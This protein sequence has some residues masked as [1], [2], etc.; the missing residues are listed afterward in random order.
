M[1]LFSEYRKIKRRVALKGEMIVYLLAIMVAVATGFLIKI[2]L[3]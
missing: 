1:S 2:I 3:K